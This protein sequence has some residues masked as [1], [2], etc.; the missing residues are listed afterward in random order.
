[1]SSF[2]SGQSGR[3]SR[4]PRA[5]DDTALQRALDRAGDGT[6]GPVAVLPSTG[7]TN[8]DAVDQV[9]EGA[10]EGFT[11]VADE[12]TQGRG[13]LDR[14][15]ASPP[16]GGIAMS[17]VLRPVV[18][19]VCWGWI[20]LIA[21]IAVVDALA[22]QAMAARL[23]WPNDV[24]VDGAARDGSAGPRKL[25]GLLVERVGGAVVVGIGLNVDLTAEELPVARATS[26]RLEGVMVSR[27]VLVVDV[28][29]HLRRRYLTWQL[30]SG[31]ARRA[32]TAEAYVERCLT[33]GRTVRA[34][35]PG[36]VVVEGVATGIDDDGRLVLSLGD[37]STRVVSA[38]DVEHLR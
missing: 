38:G 13:R 7:S 24:V 10:P 18:P 22:G 12:Q 9:G 26:T 8:A 35:L 27:E 25:G 1:V 14:S 16:G 34:L 2:V 29:D 5:W 21:G 17:V 33:L 36:G 19:D 28:L 11:V 20:P 37:G 23:K 3:P 30:A 4:D 15:W 31:D 6:W 32:G